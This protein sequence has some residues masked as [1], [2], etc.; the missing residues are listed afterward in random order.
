MSE[1]EAR[2]KDKPQELAAKKMQVVIE[3]THEPELATAAH[4][5]KIDYKAAARDALNRVQQELLTKEIEQKVKLELENEKL[6]GQLNTFEATEFEETKA[7]SS[8]SMKLNVISGQRFG[9]VPQGSKIQSIISVA[10]HQ[11]IRNLS[12][13]SEFTLMHLDTYADYL[14]QVEPRTESRVVRALLTTGGPRMKK[15][16]RRY[17]EVYG[18]YQVMLNVDGISIYTRTYVTTDDDQM[19]QIYLGEKELKVRRIGHDAMMEQDAVHIGYEAD[20][21][22]HLLDTNGTKLGVT[23]LLDTGAVVSVMPIKTWERMSFTREDLIPTNLRL[24]AANR[25]AIYV[26]GRTPTTVLHMGRRDLWMS[27]LVVENLD[28]ADQFILGRDFVRNFDVMIDLNNGLIRIRNPDR[29]Y[30]KR[31]INRI[32][33]DEKKVPIFLDRKVKLQPAQAVVA[34]FRMRNLNSLS[35]SKQVCLVPNPNSQSSVILGRSFSVTRNGLCVSVLL[36]TLD[37]TV[38]IQRGKKLGYALPMRTD[39][40][41]TQNL[42]KYSV[43]DCPYHANKDKILKR[44]SESKSIHKLFSMKSETDDG[45][46]S[47]SNFPERPSSYELESDKPVLPEIEHLKGKIGEGDF[48]KLRDL[49]NRNADVFSKH[50]ADIGCCNFV[51]HEIE[52]EEG[53]VPHREGARRMT[54]HKSEACRAEIEMLLEYDMIEPSKSPWACGVVMAKK[55]GGQLRFCCDFRYLNAVTIKD[56]Y[57][58][59]R[60]DES[61]SKLGDAKFFTTLDLGS[62]FWQVPLRKKDREKTGFACEL[63]LYQWKRMPFGLCNATA[64]FQRLMAQA[65]TRVTKKYGNLVMCYVDDVVI[66]TPTL[67]DHIDRLDEVFGCM[68]R[69]GLKCKPSKSEILRDSIK[70]LGRMVDRHGVRPDR[71]AVEAVLTWKAPRTDTQLL[72]FLGFANYYRE[73]IKGY[74]DKVYPMQKLMRNKGKKFE[75]NDEAQVAF[76][77]IKRELCEAPVLGMPTEKGMYVLDT[78]ASVVAI[79]GILHQEQE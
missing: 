5:F 15:L 79:S 47:C 8:L 59:P 12:E 70:Y 54:P 68:K 20:V 71:E 6:H 11:M 58:I 26:A 62:A 41:E 75:W 31:P 61:L 24:A 14:R 13:P 60:I 50:K 42:K 2:R 9:M 55:K 37:T 57:P 29:K 73:I 66:A 64:T 17:L 69:A 27:F 67:E 48:K 18:P 43:K 77:N 45:L 63:G 32:I 21:T 53:A 76:E 25:G 23:G 35:D 28:D 10:G 16:H 1:A 36:N 56:A 22:A 44:I 7:P 51:E 65:L 74:A 19:G 40:E 30:V 33:T 46:S 39:Y 4:D 3:E 49:L 72:S 34:I 52:L 78:D 38:S